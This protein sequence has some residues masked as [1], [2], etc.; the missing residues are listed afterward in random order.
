MKM[1][2]AA[3]KTTRDMELAKQEL[4]LKLRRE[5]DAQL[6]Q[7][8][9]KSQSLEQQKRQL[10]QQKVLELE[11]QLSDTKQLLQAAEQK[12][13]T[14]SQQLQGE[15]RIVRGNNVLNNPQVAVNKFRCSGIIIHSATATST[16]NIERTFGKTKVFLRI[17]D[18]QPNVCRL[19]CS[20]FKV[21]SLPPFFCILKQ[22]L[23]I[24]TKVPPLSVLW[25]K[26]IG[27]RQGLYVRRVKY[28]R[29]V[30]FLKC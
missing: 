27:H 20:S 26:K 3:R 1:E 22:L 24:R 28:G 6:K 30:F 10:E 18:E 13:Q 17:N 9:Q 15:V 12:T 25:V 2:L 11:K 7:E 14:V 8:L 16:S 23:L 19:L 21:M 5:L 29:H 4:E